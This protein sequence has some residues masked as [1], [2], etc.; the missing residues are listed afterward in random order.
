MPE[1]SNPS[2]QIE[3]LRD[4]VQQE[5]N[6]FRQ[7]IDHAAQLH[8]RRQEEI[9]S[10]CIASLSNND[11][12]GNHEGGTG[13]GPT[14][15]PRIEDPSL[16]KKPPKELSQVTFGGAALADVQD[17]LKS[18][19][20]PLEA[21]LYRLEG[22]LVTKSSVTGGPRMTVS[23]AVSAMSTSHRDE[24][25]ENGALL[26]N[27]RE[28][29]QGGNSR[30]AAL[31]AAPAQGDN[32]SEDS[33]IRYVSR[34]ATMSLDD[35]T[36]GGKILASEKSLFNRLVGG[37][38]VHCIAWWNSLV[39]PPR[40][41]KLAEIARS[42]AFETT[43]AV[44]IVINA[45]FSMYMVNSEIRHLQQGESTML[46]DWQR[47]V[48]LAFVLFY[49]GELIL[50][51]TVHRWYYFC[52]QD[53]GWNI[54]DAILVGL[55]IF[56]QLISAIVGTGNGG[57]DFTFMRTLRI[58]KM[59]RVL[60][61]LR[62]VRFFDEL[63]IMLN[64]LIGSVS[65]LFW[66]IVMLMITFYIFA[67]LFVQGVAN[68]L[69]E[70]RQQAVD[71]FYHGLMEEFGSVQ[72]AI[73]SLYKASTGGDD[74]SKFYNALEPTGWVYS[75]LFVFFIAFTQIAVL[76]ILT[77][78]F[79]QRAMKLAEP[80]KE[81]LALEVRH[82]DIADFEVIR[83]ILKETDTDDSGMLSAKEFS[84][85]IRIGK[86]GAQLTVLGLNIKYPL[87]FFEMI[88]SGFDDEEIEIDAFVQRCMTMRGHA[89]C[90]DV[91]LM[92]LR[93]EKMEKSQQQFETKC[94]DALVAVEE[95]LKE[96]CYGCRRV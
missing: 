40:T 57:G 16:V 77:A 71:D 75:F 26:D 65:S 27:T 8:F 82:E 51:L 92:D 47:L 42:K 21:S 24:C 90:I 4:A 84:N 62:V 72:L 29:T 83:R 63:R 17:M 12:N 36:E 19:V 86:L 10:G 87:Q 9:F 33:P 18:V 67:L 46:A 61:G 54:F 28:Q 38:C 56:D 94:I 43:C 31:L 88:A 32:F 20:Q 34:K 37:R 80:D 73:L 53:M 85:N 30:G 6:L 96:V 44:V 74:W 58:L 52:N 23:Q 69:N 89:S 50:K 66:S 59:A 91:S 11:T 55:S 35:M 39:E 13:S 7:T 78:I 25:P 48:E 95:S 3:A 2:I 70:E 14:P 22:F 49:T 5:W 93:L 76:N 45:G 15:A 79:V 1:S 60:R 64:S 81:S 41:S 68:L